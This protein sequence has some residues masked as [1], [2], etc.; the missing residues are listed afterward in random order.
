MPEVINQMS[1]GE[2]GNMKTKSVDSTRASLSA[3]SP[4]TL[5]YHVCVFLVKLLSHLPFSLLYALSDF[6]YFPSYFV[7]RYRRK[8]VRKNLTESFPDKSLDEI[9]R[10]EKRFYHFFIDMILETCKLISISEEEM[11]RRMKFTNAEM[12]HK[13]LAEGK[14]VSVFLGHYGNWEWISS[15]SLWFKEVTI[16]QIYHKLTN[17]TTNKIMK[18]LRERMGSVCIDR[19]ETVRFMATAAASNKQLIVG[20]LADQSPKTRESKHYMRFLNHTVPVLIGTE[21]AT[22]HYGYE[23]LFI[24]IKRVKR[25]YYE[26]E[27]TSLAESPASL[28]DYELTHL[29]FQRLE[30]EIRERP[31]LYLWT[32]NRFKYAHA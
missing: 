1:M 32:H 29:Y 24:D 27:L 10:I 9:V 16:A 15:S 4:D 28:P 17:N 13:M 6:L 26:C 20:F 31:E 14:S 3:S 18:R 12:L 23:A 5:S 7:L 11:R 25:G 21:K 8:I 30:S 2:E 22:K 19:Y